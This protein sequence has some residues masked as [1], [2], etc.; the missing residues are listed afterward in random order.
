MILFKALLWQGMRGNALLAISIL[1]SWAL[2]FVA[3]SAA[4]AGAGNKGNAPVKPPPP[5]PVRIEPGLEEAIKW[6]WWVEPSDEQ[7]WGVK[8]PPETILP[9]V[10]V[11]GATPGAAPGPGGEEPRPAT[12][13]V[14]KGDAWIKIAKKFGLTVVQLKTFNGKK[15]DIIRIGEVIKIPSVEELRK[16]APPPPPPPPAATVPE[17]KTPKEGARPNKEKGGK[18]GPKPPVKIEQSP[19]Y[20]TVLMQCFLDREG[21]STGAVD[22][23]DGAMFAK[24]VSLYQLSHEGLTLD[25][26]TEK[27]HAAISEP[28]ARYV[29]S[30]EDFRFILPSKP[31]APAATAAM[32][33]AAKAKGKTAANAAPPPMT[34]EELVAESMLAYRTPWEFVAERFHC[35]EAYLRRINYELKGTPGPGAEFKVPNVIPFEIEKAFEGK[36]S[37]QPASDPHA[38]VTAAIV[39]V[40]GVTRLE[41]SRNGAL[42]AAMPVSMARPDLR[43]RG[44]WN[45]LN[46]VPRPRLATQQEPKSTARP[47]KDPAASVSGTAAV[48]SPAAASDPEPASAPPAKPP[49]DKEQILAAGPNNPVGI[50]WINLAKGKSTTPLPYGLHGTSIPDRMGSQESLGG[51]RLANWDIIRAVRLL[52]PG[53]PL[54]WK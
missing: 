22:G 10:P 28:Y 6:K 1:L 51:I 12:Y 5:P 8:P 13:E 23:R 48:A 37:L 2:S 39:V 33:K 29:L 44:F 21:F 42:I 31:G 26:L 30:K 16:M 14:Q 25:A 20:K 11:P 47:P 19:E 9:A 7:E 24:M 54:Q 38:P 36:G 43:G 52:P 3:A 18:G 45:I 17:K 50:V 32:A 53:T 40:A 46:A 15:D 34:Y 35:D 49:L 4:T 41:I 27:A